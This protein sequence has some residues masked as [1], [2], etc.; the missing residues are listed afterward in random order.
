MGDFIGDWREEILMTAPD[1]KALRLYT[2][3]IPTK[4]RIY[5][6][7]HDPQYRL[8]VAWQNAVY[9]NI[10]SGSGP[11]SRAAFPGSPTRCPAAPEGDDETGMLSLL[12]GLD[13]E[14][15]AGCADLPDVVRSLP[16]F[17]VQENHDRIL[18]GWIIIF[19]NE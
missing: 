9:N 2:T 5:T 6:L 13:P 11:S 17:A 3:T 8:A 19:G 15:R 18:A 16:G 10:H 1:G 7:M 4:H 14:H 12:L